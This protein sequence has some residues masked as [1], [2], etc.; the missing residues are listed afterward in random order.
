M[1]RYRFKGCLPIFAVENKKI[2]QNIRRN[3]GNGHMRIF[4]SY[5]YGFGSTVCDVD[6]RGIV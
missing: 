5:L 3:P 2:Q 1:T 4:N 6:F